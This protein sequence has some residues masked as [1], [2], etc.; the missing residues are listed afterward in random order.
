MTTA[1]LFL[2]PVVLLQGRRSLPGRIRTM[3]SRFGSKSAFLQHL[4]S[5]GVTL[6]VGGLAGQ[7]FFHD[8]AEKVEQIW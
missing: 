7:G 6:D 1:S 2:H 3:G 8:E 5:H 4:G